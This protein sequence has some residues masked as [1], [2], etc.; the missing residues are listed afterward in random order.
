MSEHRADPRRPYKAIAAALVAVLTTLLAEG[1]DIMPPWAL[2][3]LAALL[4]G[5][6][7]YVVPN[8]TGRRRRG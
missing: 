7:T 1:R 8:P 2:L 4:A 5:L 3:V 6:V